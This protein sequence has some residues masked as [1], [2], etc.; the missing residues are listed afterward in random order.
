MKKPLALLVMCAWAL[1]AHAQN[2]VLNG[3][4]EDSDFSAHTSL[5]WVWNPEDG[6]LCW[7]TYSW[8]SY[9]QD[10]DAIAHLAFLRD[11]YAGN[12]L[13]VY[14]YPCNPE[15][16]VNNG[17]NWWHSHWQEVGVDSPAVFDQAIAD[18]VLALYPDLYGSIYGDGTWDGYPQEGLKYI[19]ASAN[20]TNLSGSAAP[21]HAGFSLALSEPLQVGEWYQLRYWIM[22]IQPPYSGSIYTGTNSVKIGFSM[23]DT[24]FGDSVHLSYF[25]NR[26][27]DTTWIQQE[28]YFQ[29]QQPYEH[30][31]CMGYIRHELYGYRMLLLDN[32]SVEWC[33]TPCDTTS[34]IEPP[35][36]PLDS[37]QVGLSEASKQLLSVHPNPFVDELH[38]E[39]SAQRLVFYDLRGR[40]Q[41]RQ[42]LSN[43]TQ[44]IRLD[45]LPIGIYLLKAYDEQGN[46]ID[47]KKLIKIRQQ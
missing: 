22:A 46:Q 19:G 3:S 28:T 32:F 40:E 47:Q 25:P 12:A 27:E 26:E 16:G 31:T 7:S 34:A 45:H 37:N 33:P 14:S 21:H 9:N 18:S 11:T 8:P 5:W 4:F 15:C 35:D 30:L 24:L 20:D 41:H 42:V 38:I 13:G 1:L 29:A 2:L 43:N 44:A 10:P 39:S 6:G 17:T 23:L 36:N